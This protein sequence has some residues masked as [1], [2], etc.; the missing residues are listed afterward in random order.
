MID[1]EL[2][3]LERTA[4]ERPGDEE[5]AE[6]LDRAQRR[7]GQRRTL[8]A[9]QVARLAT[10]LRAYQFRTIVDTLVW[11]RLVRPE[12][13]VLEPLLMIEFIYDPKRADSPII[14]EMRTRE[15]VEIEFTDGSPL[16]FGP[17]HVFS[18]RV[19][20]EWPHDTEERLQEDE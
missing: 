14:V 6:R 4:Q 12:R 7:A 8:H 1:A 3:V 9:A 2:R 10:A 16:V 19:E 13:A 11:D 18:F 15:N 20:P 5:A 17:S